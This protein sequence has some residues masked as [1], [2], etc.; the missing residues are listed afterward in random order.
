VHSIYIDTLWPTKLTPQNRIAANHTAALRLLAIAVIGSALLALSAKIQVPFWPV[1]MTMQTYVVLAL[2]A[3]CGWKL[4]A[5]TIALYLAEGAAGLPVFANVSTG[6]SYIMG[7]TGGYLAGFL[8]S[9]L[10]VGYLA[11]KGATHSLPKML[12]VM[13]LGHALIFCFG[14]AWLATLIGPEKA[15]AAGVAPFYAATALKT[16]LAASTLPALWSLTKR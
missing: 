7:P 2:A 15:F 6:L 4:G 1:P 8:V 14:F 9:A 13:T 10:V 16:L 11:E 3:A 5:F 12:A